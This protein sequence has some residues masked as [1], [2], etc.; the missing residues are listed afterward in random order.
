MAA[1]SAQRVAVAGTAVTYQSAASGGDTAPVGGGLKLHVA[2]G[3]AS[4][5]TVTVVTPG[6]LDGLAIAD[7]AL[8]IPA[9]G[10]GFIPLT[11]VYRDP[12]TGRANIT[13]SAVTSVN[14]AVISD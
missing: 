2:N 6:T 5:I 10:N 1:I 8:S 3:G 4:P 13:Y 9:S 14:V 11:S 12:V 7:A